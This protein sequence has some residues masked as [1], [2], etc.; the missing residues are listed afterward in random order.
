[1]GS[2]ARLNGG[3]SLAI[4][5]PY[6]PKEVAPIV[7]GALALVIEVASKVLYDIEGVMLLCLA[8]TPAPQV[9]LFISLFL[10][11]L[12][13]I[14]NTAQDRI[15]RTIRVTM[16]PMATAGT[17]FGLDEAELA[18]EIPSAEG[19]IEGEDKDVVLGALFVSGEDVTEALVVGVVAA[20]EVEGAE[21][22]EEM[23]LVVELVV[24]GVAG[25]FTVEE[26]VAGTDS[27]DGSGLT[28]ATGVVFTTFE[29]VFL[30]FLLL[31]FSSSSSELP[32]PEPLLPEPP[33]P[34]SPLPEPPL[35][36]PLLP[37][38]SLPESPSLP[39]ELPKIDEMGGKAGNPNRRRFSS[40]ASAGRRLP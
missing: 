22:V 24:D 1:M 35:P 11:Y 5:A 26:V 2:D 40:K 19:E 30:V 20:I 9:I 32:L 31:S 4:A 28:A 6:V 33:L 12:F 29:V 36:E 21:E 25:L 37:E 8:K 23:V 38:P 14:I 18:E 17:P 13:L 34:E 3:V 16:T 27:C 39:P 10:M 15:A 7:G